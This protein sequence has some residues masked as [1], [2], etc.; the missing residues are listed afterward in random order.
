MVLLQ[1]QLRDIII[2]ITKILQQQKVIGSLMNFQI[3]VMVML[4]VRYRI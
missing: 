3:A 1:L 4:L 2:I